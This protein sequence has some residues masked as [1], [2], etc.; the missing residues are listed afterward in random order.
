MLRLHKN[1]M[2]IFLNIMPQHLIRLSENCP[3]ENCLQENCSLKNCLPT[4]QK[5]V[6]YEDCPL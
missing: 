4:P 2:E 3:P 5:I 1:M 6:T